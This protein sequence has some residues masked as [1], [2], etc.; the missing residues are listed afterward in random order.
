MVDSSKKDTD[1]PD[2]KDDPK[3]T[4]GKT[5]GESS[6][7]GGDSQS[8]SGAGQGGTGG[9][10][11]GSQPGSDS[12]LNRPPSPKTFNGKYNPEF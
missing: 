12:T 10:A 11:Y 8:G 5:P 4:G 6:K 3:K 1:N 2:K 9:G 7:S